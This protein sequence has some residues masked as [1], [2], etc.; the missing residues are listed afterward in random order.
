V[1][2]EWDTGTN[3]V[4]F[5]GG[6]GRSLYGISSP[7]IATLVDLVHE[8]DL[9]VHMAS[10]H[11]TLSTGQPYVNEYR[12]RL[13]DGAI[14]WIR[15]VAHRMPGDDRRLFGVSNEVTGR[16]QWPVEPPP[17]GAMSGL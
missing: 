4:V 15:S 11:R 2:F 1:A 13:P 9:A 7:D 8:D 5:L 16:P 3:Q 17:P 10:L 6:D 14:R 12:I